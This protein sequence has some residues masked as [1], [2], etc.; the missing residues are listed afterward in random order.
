MVGCLALLVMRVKVRRRIRALAELPQIQPDVFDSSAVFGSADSARVRLLVNLF[1][2]DLRLQVQVH[3]VPG[4]KFYPHTSVR[5]TASINHIIVL[6]YTFFSRHTTSV[7]VVLAFLTRGGLDAR[8]STLVYLV[9]VSALA[10]LLGQTLNSERVT[11][12]VAL[13]LRHALLR[14]VVVAL[15]YET[16]KF[17]TLCCSDALVVFV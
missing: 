10:L 6:Q 15:V 16:T 14:T 4:V 11:S 13:V 5:A 2:V 9:I 17:H 1:R 7:V 3:E 12:F 8:A